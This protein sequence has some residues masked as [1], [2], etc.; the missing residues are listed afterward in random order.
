MMS[1]IGKTNKTIAQE[2]IRYQKY[3]R[4][5]IR[6]LDCYRSDLNIFSAYLDGRKLSILS[7]DQPVIDK[8]VKASLGKGNKIRS[9]MRHLASMRSMY[10]WLIK[11]KCIL[12]NPTTG[13]LLPKAPKRFPIAF[14]EC[15]IKQLFINLEKNSSYEGI[16]NLAIVELLYSG[17]RSGNVRD[18]Q[19]KEL[20]MEDRYIKI[21]AK[22][23]EEQIYPFPNKAHKSLELWLKIR[24]GNGMS[25]GRVFTT[26]RGMALSDSEFL[27]TIKNVCH[28]IK[29]GATPRNFR[30]TIATHL[31]SAGA[32]G[33]DINHIL[34]H[35]SMDT[36]LI[37]IEMSAR[38]TANVIDRLSIRS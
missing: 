4:R 1:L 32:D 25:K 13:Y 29:P 17:P 22:G 5:S 7:I 18:L 2:F 12:H 20:N 33:M 16:R 14:T 23:N 9:V 34:H 30:A 31:A 36:T 35:K 24:K 15:E 8:Y 21:I 19:V 27:N 3:M 6:T 37:Y 11:E 26:R 28:K 38:Q 10:T